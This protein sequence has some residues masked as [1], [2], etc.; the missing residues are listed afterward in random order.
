MRTILRRPDLI[1]KS[2]QSFYTGLA[3]VEI[4][5]SIKDENGKIRPVVKV[6]YED[7]PCRLSHESKN[8]STGYERNTVS[9]TI[10]LFLDNEPEI[11]AGAKIT[12][13]QDGVKNVYGCASEPNVFE[14]HQEI[15]LVLWEDWSGTRPKRS[16]QDVQGD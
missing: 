10:M 13:L 15:E 2:I 8:P 3:T 1:K 5:E 6:E 11:P 16:G 7:L 12:V 9:Q 14:T 4:K